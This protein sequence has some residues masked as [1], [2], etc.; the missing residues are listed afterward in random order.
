M[1]TKLKER[2]KL[3]KKYHKNG[4]MNSDLDEVIA[5]SNECA[6]AISAAKGKYIK[7]MREKFNDPLAAP[8]SY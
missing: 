7:Q 5:K 8:K 1:K 2:L 3:T 6:E 4:D